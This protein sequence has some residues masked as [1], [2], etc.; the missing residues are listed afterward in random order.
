MKA[1]C[2]IVLILL[3]QSFYTNG[4][5]AQTLQI[6]SN[7]NEKMKQ[8]IG[9]WKFEALNAPVGF[10]SGTV[11][12]HKDSLFVIYDGNPTKYP[13]IWIKVKNDS[14]LFQFY[15]G[16]VDVL[17]RLKKENEDKI[18]GITSWIG[19]D[20]PVIYIRRKDAELKDK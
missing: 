8:F 17:C 7:Q 2:S 12:I 6:I 1:Y 18:I 13:S 14:L 9:S 4:M 15:N 16:I 10:N 20:S 11:E 3:F 19:S 5:Q